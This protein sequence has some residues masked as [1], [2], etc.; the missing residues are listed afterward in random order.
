[1]TAEKGLSPGEFAAE[2]AGLRRR[3]ATSTAT[4]KETLLRIRDSLPLDAPQR[5]VIDGLLEDGEAVSLLSSNLDDLL[6]AVERVFRSAE[7]STR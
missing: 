3:I 4:L 7:T 6:A 1:M 2:V 5:E